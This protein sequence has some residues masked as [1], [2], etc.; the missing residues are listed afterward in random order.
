MSKVS[1]TGNA[2]G[3][4][5]FTIAAPNSNT[6]RTLTLPDETGTLLTSAS[7]LGVSQLPAQLSVNGSASSGSLAIDSSG[8]VTMPY[9]PIFQGNIAS[10]SPH[11][12]GALT[13]PVNSASINNGNHFNTSTYTFTCPVSGYYHMHGSFMTDDYAL[14]SSATGSTDIRPRK[15]GSNIGPSWY[16][17]LDNVGHQVRFSG[18]CIVYCSANDALTFYQAAG[19]IHSGGYNEFS[20]RLIA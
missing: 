4:G 8:R 1:I 9:Q 6:D 12:N 19:K 17:D 5:T 10:Q 2:S 20:I 3:T 13:L 15:N 14:P 16:T 11:P 18:D 7:S